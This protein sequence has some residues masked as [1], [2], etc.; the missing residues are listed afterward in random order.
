MIN[1]SHAELLAALDERLD[2]LLSGSAD[3]LDLTN[4]AADAL[5]LQQLLTAARL[6][7]QVLNEPLPVDT[8]ARHLRLIEA[9]ARRLAWEQGAPPT[10][11]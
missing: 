9:A 8:R 6:T 10:Q 7:M 1:M 3:F 5:E 11:G 4:D 2:A